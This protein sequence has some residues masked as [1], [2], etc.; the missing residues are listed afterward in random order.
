ML[1]SRIGTKTGV[2]TQEVQLDSE[3]SHLEK[4]SL[5][6][7]PSLVSIKNKYL[8]SCRQWERVREKTIK[9]REGKTFSYL[10]PH[11]NVQ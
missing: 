6:S 4:D 2:Q 3:V 10:S 1:L 9:A 7:E 5:E 8:L 11:E